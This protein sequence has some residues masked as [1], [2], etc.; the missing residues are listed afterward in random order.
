MSF[1]FEKPLDDLE[2]RI[3]E[4]I[5]LQTWPDRW[6]GNEPTADMPLDSVFADGTVQPL[7]IGAL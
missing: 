1:D 3:R 2:A 5:T 4:L 7:L 6:D